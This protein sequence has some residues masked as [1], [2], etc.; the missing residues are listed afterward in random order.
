LEES[1]GEIKIGIEREIAVKKGKR[2]A[3]YQN[4]IGGKLGM[5]INGL[6]V[7]DLEDAGPGRKA[8]LLKGDEIIAINGTPTRYMPF[9]EAVQTIQKCRGSEVTF[10]VARDATLWRK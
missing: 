3:S 10:N 2:D 6:T 4:I 5:L 8:G 9:K 1:S 7:T